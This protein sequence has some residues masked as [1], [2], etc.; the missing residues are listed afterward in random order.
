MHFLET[1]DEIITYI[2]ILKF[3]QMETFIEHLAKQPCHLVLLSHF[4][5]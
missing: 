5:A 3:K 4:I 1:F 2:D